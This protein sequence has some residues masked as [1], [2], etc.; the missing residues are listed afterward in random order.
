MNLTELSEMA[1][2]VLALKDTMNKTF[3]SHPEVMDENLRLA[4]M[5]GLKDA[6]NKGR[7]SNSITEVLYNK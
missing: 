3:N 6:Y 4:I 7:R 2:K 5:A 1:D